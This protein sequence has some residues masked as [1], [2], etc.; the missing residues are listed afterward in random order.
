MMTKCIYCGGTGF[1]PSPTDSPKN[2]CTRCTAGVVPVRE[3]PWWDALPG[4][5]NE[6]TRELDGE[7]ADAEAERHQ[8]E[9]GY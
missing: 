3:R 1:I 9:Q 8:R 4:D 5:Y 7:R 2:A 6:L